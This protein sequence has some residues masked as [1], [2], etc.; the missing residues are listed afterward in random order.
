MNTM[1]SF[2]SLPT[3]FF[4][5]LVISDPEL[6]A[7]VTEAYGKPTDKSGGI[8]VTRTASLNAA[9][10]MGIKPGKIKGNKRAGGPG[11]RGG[12]VKEVS[13]KPSPRPFVALTL[14]ANGPGAQHFL[15]ALLMAGKRIR[16]YDTATVDEVT[17]ETHEQGD[18]MLDARGEP[19]CYFGGDSEQRRDEWAAIEAC[20]SGSDRSEAHGCQLDQARMLANTDIRRTLGG[21]VMH[22]DFHYSGLRGETVT[23]TNVI[24]RSGIAPAA[25]PWRSPESHAATWSAAGF[26][27]GCPLPI[28]KILGDLY[29]RERLAT[30]EMITLGKLQELVVDGDKEGYEKLIS[31]EYQSSKEMEIV[32]GADGITVES[33][34][35]VQKEH[36]V[37]QALRRES[38]SSLLDGLAKLE[39]FAGARLAVI[40]KDIDGLNG[41]PSADTVERVY[42]A[43]L[44]RGSLATLEE[45]VMSCYDPASRS[46]YTL[47][48]GTVL[49]AA[50]IE[51][52]AAKRAEESLWLT[53]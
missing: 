10:L 42:A 29:A 33:Y 23:V 47:P 43:M 9:P 45:T 36:P 13:D 38:G 19:L 35:T 5:S 20:F 51:R 12:K 25:H 44:T 14:R 52:L 24:T 15:S 22:R 2:T 18:P 16:C 30:A 11:S 21:T 40:Q 34:T 49:D 4:A 26:V 28:R 31:A 6:A 46:Y 7:Y 3:S 8:T 37:V 27:A 32:Y 17:G 1:K 53:K 39:A 50:P 41:K 48:V